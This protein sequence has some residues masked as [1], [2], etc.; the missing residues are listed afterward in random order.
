MRVLNG[1]KFLD[2]RISRTEME[3]LADIL[4]MAKELEP[5]KFPEHPTKVDIIAWAQTL[6]KLL[7]RNEVWHADYEDFPILSQEKTP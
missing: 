3:M 1:D 4:D 5:K 2:I 7:Q 6:R